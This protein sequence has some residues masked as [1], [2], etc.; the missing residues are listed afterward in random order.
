MAHG[1]SRLDPSVLAPI[2]AIR[3]LRSAQLAAE[4]AS[5]EVVILPICQRWGR[6]AP[7]AGAIVFDAPWVPWAK[8]SFL[9]APIPP[10]LP[11]GVWFTNPPLIAP[12]EIRVVAV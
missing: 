6:P 12:W 5:W 2:G 10:L 9:L 11:A 4:L 7:R 8:P 3:L 1:P